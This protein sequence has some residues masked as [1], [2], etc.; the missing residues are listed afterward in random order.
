VQKH[1]VEVTLIG[2][3]TIVVDA[4]DREDARKKAILKFEK[5]FRKRSAME[6]KGK[7]YDTNDVVVVT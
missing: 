2:K 5:E 1:S 4:K 3:A 6:L 7:V